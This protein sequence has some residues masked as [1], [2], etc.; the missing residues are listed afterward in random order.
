[1]DS[2]LVI[3]WT[4]GL[5]GTL[6][7]A[8]LIS[9]GLYPLYDTTEARYGEM[10]RI[11]FETQNWVTPMFDYNVPFWGKPPMQTWLSAASF[12]LFGVSEFSA[13]LPHF[14]CGLGTL[15]AVYW[16][17]K[18][19]ISL[20]HAIIS[21]LVLTSTLG[22]ILASGMVMT[23][24]ILLLAVTGAMISF[25]C[26]YREN[27]RSVAGHVF[28]ASLA[29][30]MLVKGPVAIV[31]VGIALVS[32]SIWQRCFVAAIKSLPWI[33][34]LVIFL[35][36]ALPWYIWAEV[37][38]PGF[39]NYFIW[40]EHVQRFLVSGWQGD[41]YGSAHDE[42]RGMIWLLWLG[43]A[44]P[45]SFYLVLKLILTLK[46]KQ[47]QASENPMISYLVC[48]M[49][50][51]MLLFT[52]AGNILPAYVLP[53][54]SAMAVLVSSQMKSPSI[55]LANALV[56]SVVF[57]VLIGIVLSGQFDKSS[58]ASL[59]GVNRNFPQ[60]DQLYYWHKRPFS[61]QFYSKGQAQLLQDK[62]QLKRLLLTKTPFDLALLNQDLVDIKPL[63]ESH[64][65]LVNRST[66]RQLYYCR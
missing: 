60:D 39:L 17:V 55:L 64:C 43:A 46:D 25:W 11:M 13:R 40:G 23:D 63:V 34:G 48:W 26:C 58:E 14:L 22:F 5:I 47:R 24:S 4:L 49:I 12:E 51:P 36:L 50:A 45:W 16:W 61:A 42:P 57:I 44:F 7:L 52:M 6:V 62:E 41:L 56:S 31:I 32:W 21:V 27:D 3:R 53:G 54:F 33:S 28:F 35:V 18:R 15:I 66:I 20:F 37:R 30:G 19:Y 2:K 10:A 8:R 29:L 38:S 9:L 1:M 59:L 65:Q